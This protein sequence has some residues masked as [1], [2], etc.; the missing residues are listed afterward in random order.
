MMYVSHRLHTILPLTIFQSEITDD[1]SEASRP[2]KR[3][4]KEVLTE[5]SIQH[6]QSESTGRKVIFD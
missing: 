2:K 1:G 3:K 4:T 6:Q 5:T